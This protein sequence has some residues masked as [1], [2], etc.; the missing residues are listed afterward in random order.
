VLRPPVRAGADGAFTMTGM[1]SGSFA[2]R[3]TGKGYENKQFADVT[4]GGARQTFALAR[5]ASN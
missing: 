2:I 3:A 5:E 4:A 1:P